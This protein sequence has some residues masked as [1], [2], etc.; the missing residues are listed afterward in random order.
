MG[1]LGATAQS[2]GSRSGIVA[3]GGVKTSLVL[4]RWSGMTGP[5]SSGA[6]GSKSA[7]SSGAWPPGVP[8]AGDD[9]PGSGT[10]KIS[11]PVEAGRPPFGSAAQFLFGSAAMGSGMAWALCQRPLPWIASSSTRHSIS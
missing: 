3:L 1:A 5:E 8:P 10:E 4:G 7:G 6:K 2:S 11:I 9:R